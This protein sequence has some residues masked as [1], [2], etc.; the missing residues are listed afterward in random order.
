MTS[1][2]LQSMTQLELLDL[3]SG[4]SQE[5]KDR[6]KREKKRVYRVHLMFEAAKYYINY[7]NA[8][9][10]LKDELN[11]SYTTEDFLAESDV[12]ISISVYF[13]EEAHLKNC[14][15]YLKI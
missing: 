4:I 11:N 14:E 13:I 5:F 1:K 9:E 10:A 3:Q 7:E 6:E 8:V 2:E 15:D 12:S